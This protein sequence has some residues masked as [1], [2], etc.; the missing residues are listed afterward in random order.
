MNEFEGDLIEA[1]YLKCEHKF[2]PTNN[3]LVKSL[4]LRNV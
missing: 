3:D 1:N 2:R 4:H